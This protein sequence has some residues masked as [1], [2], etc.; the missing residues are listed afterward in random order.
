MLAW[1]FIRFPP[2]SK[3]SRMFRMFRMF[4]M[5]EAFGFPMVF[6]KKSKTESSPTAMTALRGDMFLDQTLY[7]E[8]LANNKNA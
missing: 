3:T 2:V 8:R 7:A 6:G 4:R 5:S 1:I